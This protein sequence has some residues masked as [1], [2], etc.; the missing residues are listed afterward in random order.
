MKVF[1]QMV[2]L[3]LVI[4]FAVVFSS[5]YSNAQ[6]CDVSSHVA[7]FDCHPEKDPTKEKCIAQKCCWRLLI[8]DENYTKERL[9]RFDVPFYYYPKD[10]PTYAVTSNQTTD[11]G[12]DFVLLNHKQHTCQMIFLI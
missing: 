4:V 3:F 11:F 7:R 2:R 12:N 1:D 9:S 5:Y 6:Q 10:F 8:E